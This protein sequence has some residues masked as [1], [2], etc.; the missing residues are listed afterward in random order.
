M[1]FRKGSSSQKETFEGRHRS[2][3]W[4]RDNT[5]YFLTTRCTDRIPAF[6]TEQAKEIFWRQFNKYS[7]AHGFDVWVCTLVDNHYHAVGHLQNAA[8][9]AP[10]LRKIHG[11]VSKLVNDLLL[12]RALPFWSDYFDGCL[13]DE[14][15]YRRAYRYTLMQSVRHGICKDWRNYS[16]THVHRSLE[17]GLAIALKRR[18]FLPT[19][20]YQRYE[21]GLP[22]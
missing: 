8:M 11:S 9:L 15:Q 6:A 10:M 13:R 22:T 17:D 2:E 4:Y 3:H 18:A 5:V 19:I 21:R 20:P 16:H 14:T 12:A 1:R 7:V